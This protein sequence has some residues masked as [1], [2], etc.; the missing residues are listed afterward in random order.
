MK[1]IAISALLA[2]VMLSATEYN[3]EV[4]P[5]WGNASSNNAQELEDQDVYGAEIQF[6]N[7]DTFFKP[8]L[9]VFYSDG[10]YN[11]G[12]RRHQYF[13]NGP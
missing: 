2:A 7:C 4:S 3:Y 8:E 12:Q 1:K 9:S 10:T 5:M 6:N 13:Q 11:G